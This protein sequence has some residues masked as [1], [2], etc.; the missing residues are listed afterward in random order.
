[1]TLWH[2]FNPNPQPRHLRMSKKLDPTTIDSIRNDIEFM[3]HQSDAIRQHITMES[4][5]NGDEPGMGKSLIGLACDGI[6]RQQRINND[7]TLKLKTLVVCPS[8][9][10][11]NWA[12]EIEKMTNLRPVV[13]TGGPA[14][15]EVILDEFGHED[16]GDILIVNYEILSKHVGDIKDMPVH[17]VS[18]IFDE[19]H[20]IKSPKSQRTKASFRVRDAMPRVF[21]MTGTP[22]MNRVTELW[23]VLHMIDPEVWRNAFQF[24]RRYAKM[25]GY[26]GKVV[27]GA[28]NKRELNDRLQPIMVRRRKADVLDLPPKIRIQIPVEMSPLQRKLYKEAKNELRLTV[29][30]STSD[31]MVMESALVAAG[32][33]K[34]IATT[35]F[36]VQY[37][38]KDSPF[39]D[40]SNKLDLI[41]AKS[42][43][44]IENGDRPIIFTEY[45]GA[46]EALV[47]RFAHKKIGLQAFQLHG[48][49]TADKRVPLVEEWGSASPTPLIAITKV[50]GQGLNMAQF[51]KTAIFATRNWTPSW[52]EQAENRIHR[53]GSGMTDSVN[54]INP[55]VIDTIEERVEN[56][57][58]EKQQLTN[59]IVDGQLA[60][61]AIAP[62]GA[63]LKRKLY[64]LLME[65]LES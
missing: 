22:I 7:P 25:G 53:V 45:R 29:P 41:V 55:V 38:G 10:R 36:A 14:K 54:I 50:A 11:L 39:K 4:W 12:R 28:K 32:R 24:Q 42:I 57:L 37:D 6:A 26:E 18:G 20:Y 46:V 47:R 21:M 43:E 5:L 63:D 62:G 2:P 9:L 15:R 52:N 61:E 58:I 51:S 60:D 1:M 13:L 40:E 23:P 48:G 56:V 59:E 3:A 17:W 49:I 19:C 27:V 16:T 33:L 8:T 31:P 34:Q 44:T 65:E 30:G 64:E 35:P